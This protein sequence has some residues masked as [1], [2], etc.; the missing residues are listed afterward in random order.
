MMV[1][2]LHSGSSRQKGTL[3]AII[4]AENVKMILAVKGS[5]IHVPYLQ[6]PVDTQGANLISSSS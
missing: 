6:C 5:S 1:S 2:A 4:A 3:N